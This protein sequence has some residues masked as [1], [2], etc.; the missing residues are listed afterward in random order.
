MGLCLCFCLFLILA[1]RNDLCRCGGECWLCQLWHE[2]SWVYMQDVKNKR[3]LCHSW[4]RADMNCLMFFLSSNADPLHQL[5]KAMTLTVVHPAFYEGDLFSPFLYSSFQATSQRQTWAQERQRDRL[6]VAS[7]ITQNNR[8]SVW[9]KD[10]FIKEEGQEEPKRGSLLERQSQY[11]LDGIVQGLFLVT[12]LPL[13]KTHF[14]LHVRGRDYWAQ[15]WVCMQDVSYQ[16]PIVCPSFHSAT[17]IEDRGGLIL[18]FVCHVEQLL[19]ER[20][21]DLSSEDSRQWTRDL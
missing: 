3:P 8:S 5:C 7:S 21:M 17:V 9:K 1:R 15:T 2:I 11:R 6:S 16:L 10:L 18:F 12:C 19:E 14:C 13:F 4:Q 20:E